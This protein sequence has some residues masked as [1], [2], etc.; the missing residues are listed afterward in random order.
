MTP[1][2]LLAAAQRLL[3][4]P[5]AKTAA[6][7]PRAAAL[8]A[9]QALEQGLDTYWRTKGLKLDTLGTKPQLIC[10]QAYMP[11]GATAGR[12]SHAWSALTQ[13][14]HHH[15]YELQASHAELKDW[16]GA[17][18]DMVEATSAPGAASAPPPPARGARP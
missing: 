2:D 1:T 6:I 16:L 4:R 15:P 18:A 17:V 14:C 8:L 11:D 7:W 3:D 9:R 10:L 13:L 5:D 12:A